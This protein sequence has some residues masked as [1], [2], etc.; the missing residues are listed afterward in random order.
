MWLAAR[1]IIGLTGYP[2]ISTYDMG[3]VGLAGY[4]LAEG[5]VHITNPASPK[6]SV[7]MFNISNMTTRLLGQE[8]PPSTWTRW[9][10]SLRSPSSGWP[11]AP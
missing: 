10:S 5:W 11:F 3:A 8:R 1:E 6:L 9:L 2:P 7:K 4:V